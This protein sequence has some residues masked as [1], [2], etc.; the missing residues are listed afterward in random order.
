M[1]N[2]ILK[3]VIF[4]LMLKLFFIGDW[5]RVH[6][7]APGPPQCTGPHRGHWEQVQ[8]QRQQYQVK[9]GLG[10]VYGNITTSETVYKSTLE[11][12]YRNI[13]SNMD[14]ITIQWDTANTVYSNLRSSL[15]TLSVLLGTTWIKSQ[16][17]MDK[18]YIN[19]RFTLDTG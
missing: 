18:V 1:K 11:T 10:S 16:V 4:F 17:N 7:P 19:I 9:H 15:D 6:A 8:N 14:T 2:K 5:R 13:R 3:N 12:I